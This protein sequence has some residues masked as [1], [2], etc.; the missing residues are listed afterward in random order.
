MATGISCPPRLMRTVW[1][2]ISRVC[3]SFSKKETCKATWLSHGDG[4][5]CLDSLP[6]TLH[7]RPAQRRTLLGC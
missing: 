4:W 7:M 2:V 6:M 5:R 1:Q 3:L